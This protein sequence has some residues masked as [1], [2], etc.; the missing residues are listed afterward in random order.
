M[1]A[2]DGLFLLFGA[3]YGV[4]PFVLADLY[5][6]WRAQRL[7]G[8]T[9]SREIIWRAWCWLRWPKNDVRHYGARGDGETDDSEAFKRA[10]RRG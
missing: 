5:H 4:A 10:V 1:T 3:L 2:R 7:T 8:A 9:P 6:R